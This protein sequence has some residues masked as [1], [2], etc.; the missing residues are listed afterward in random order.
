MPPGAAPLHDDQILLTDWRDSPLKDAKG[1]AKLTLTYFEAESSSGSFV[2]K[3]ATFQLAGHVPLAGV[4]LDSGLTPELP[5]LTDKV[6]ATGWEAPPP[7]DNKSIRKLIKPDDVNELYWENYRTTPK[8]YITL[9]RGQQ[10]WSSRFGRLD[11]HSPRPQ[12]R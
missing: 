6:S 2:E 10:L 8:A 11:V 4:A 12:E 1:G 7:F 3:S 5:G 9:A